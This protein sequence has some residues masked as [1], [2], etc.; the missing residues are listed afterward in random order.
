MKAVMSGIGIVLLVRSEILG[1]GITY[2]SQ[3]VRQIKLCR[4]IPIL[5]TVKLGVF[6][7]L[8]KTFLGDIKQ[9][10]MRGG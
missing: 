7:N 3:K 6:N 9:K 4:H 2:V 10:K 8:S 5:E 1:T